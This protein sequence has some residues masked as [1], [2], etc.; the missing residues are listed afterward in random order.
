MAGK[1]A[2]TMVMMVILVGLLRDQPGVLSAPVKPESDE[3]SQMAEQIEILGTNQKRILE[4]VTAFKDVLADF[5]KRFLNLDSRVLSIESRYK[6]SQGNY[7]Q[8]K[9][10]ILERL[11]NIETSS[12]NI[13]RDMKVINRV[14]NKILALDE[15]QNT[16]AEVLA[17]TN[18]NIVAVLNTKNESSEVQERLDS[19]IFRVESLENKTASGA[20]Q[21]EGMLVNSTCGTCAATSIAEE[22]LAEIVTTVESRLGEL[23]WAQGRSNGYQGQSSGEQEQSDETLEETSG[24]QEGSSGPQ[25]QSDETLEETSREQGS[26]GAPGQSDE[27]L[28]EK[29]RQQEG[30]SGPQG[31]SDGESEETSD[32]Q[33]SSG[34]QGQSD[35]TAEETSGQQ[36]GSSG[37]QGQPDQTLEESSRQQQGLSWPQEQPD[38]TWEETWEQQEGSGWDPFGNYYYWLSQEDSVTNSKKGNGKAWHKNGQTR[39]SYGRG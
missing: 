2:V 38:F 27:T 30:S 29:S 20:Q 5:E 21:H 37:A 28:E 31:Q 16:F 7:L 22:L 35:Q 9:N 24:Q 3:K 4:T 23:S 12:Q 33:G 1:C 6:D 18:K 19:V 32:K 8:E 34:P 36:K 10:D 39:P 17:T 26:I 13:T 15:R 14:D 25:G 11:G